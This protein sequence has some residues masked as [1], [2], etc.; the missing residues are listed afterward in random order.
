MP[1]TLLL[2]VLLLVLAAGAVTWLLWLRPAGDPRPTTPTPGDTPVAPAAVDAAE[3]GAAVEQPVTPAVA[4]REQVPEVTDVIAPGKAL[5]RVTTRD[6]AGRAQPN[7]MV[8]A[9]PQRGSR[10]FAVVGQG[11]TDEHGRIE[12][13]GLEP[14]KLYLSTDRRDQK[15]VEIVP[16]LNE[17]DFEVRAGIDV[18]GRVLDPDG[19]PVAGAEVW[20]QT[21]SNAWDGGR[22]LG[23]TG[24]DGTFSLANVAPNCSLGAFASGFAPS[25][26]LDLEVV[27]QSAPPARV[28]LRLARDGGDLT[29]RVTDGDGQPLR[30]AQVAVGD[31][32]KHA[33]WERDRVIEVWG[34]RTVET[35]EHGRYAFAG[36]PAGN[37]VVT[38]RASGFGICRSEARVTAGDTATLDL[39]LAKSASLFG[40]VIDGNGAPEAGARISA[41]DREP[42]TH[43]VAGGQ[44]DFDLPF[45]HVETAADE[46]G[47]YRLEGLTPGTVWSFALRRMDGRFGGVSVALRR[48]TLEVAAGSEVRWDPVIDSG[49]SIEGVVRYRD[50]YPIPHLFIT[51]HDERTGEDRTINS[52]KE[53]RFRFLCLDDS[54]YEVRVQPP[55]DAPRGNVPPRRSGV[56]PDRAPVELTVEYDKPQKVAPG[57]VRGRIADTG[58]RIRNPIAATV[59]LNS[60][61]GWFRPG[62][63]VEGGAFVVDEVE[64]CRFRIILKEGETVLASTDWF[65]LAAAGDVDVGLL[66]TEPGGALRVHASRAKGAEGFEPK[67]YLRRDGDPLS[68]TIALGRADEAFADSMTPGTYEVSGYCKG[69][70]SVKSTAVVRAGE[71]S[72]LGVELRPGAVGKVEVWWPEGH[73]ASQRRGYKVTDAGGKVVQEYEGPLYTSPTRPYEMHFTLAAGRHHLEFWT[74]DELRGELDFE[75]PADLVAPAL[76]LDLK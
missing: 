63:K 53:G 50:G 38:A 2:G 46:H 18:V 43:F 28:E 9:R 11:L 75:I 17:V 39:T 71:T 65:E 3:A 72:Q 19:A 47:D 15:N 23:A 16:G 35:D 36:V 64:P 41:Y 12:F 33:D 21:A 20:L 45:G 57:T 31:Q 56:V 4:E 76:R 32:A 30:G 37:N 29:G 25:A 70:L 7:V 73:S 6:P 67:L 69:M 66:T 74:D 34:V 44:I 59:T 51:L 40:K 68:T 58:A 42:G 27:D 54:T 14:C 48:D 61:A 55:F 60:D 24:D 10:I 62:I 26:L 5:V 49:R 52:D 8:I 22:V 13:Q 1:R